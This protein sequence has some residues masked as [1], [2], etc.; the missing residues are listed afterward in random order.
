MPSNEHDKIIYLRWATRTVLTLL[1]I[2]LIGYIVYLIFG[3]NRL[4]EDMHNSLS[5]V[6]GGLLLNFGK[7]SS[8]WF[9]KSKSDEK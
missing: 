9:E 4:A 1:E 3:E 5:V 8:F 7:S 6:L 2:V